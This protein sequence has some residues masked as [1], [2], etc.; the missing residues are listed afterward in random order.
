MRMNGKAF[1]IA[2]TNLR[3][4]LRART[5]IF[6]IFVFPMLLILILGLAFGGSDSPRVGVVAPSQ[7]DLAG[8][9]VGDLRASSGIEV[10]RIGTEAELTSKVEHSELAG[11]LVVPDDYD[12]QVRAGRTVTLRYLAQAGQGGQQ[13]GAVVSAAVDRQSGRILAARAVAGQLAIGFDDSLAR[14]DRA[15]STVDLVTVVTSTTGTTQVPQNA[16]RFDTGASSQLLL[17]LFITSL[18]SSIALIES[19]RLGVSTRMAATPTPAHTII[20]GEGLGR[21]AVA[22]IQALFIM[23]GSALIFGVSWGNPLAAAA[24]TVAFALVASAAGL[25]LGASARTPEQAI[26]VGLLLGMGMGALGGTM[27]PLEFFSPT[28]RRIA[29]ITPHAWGMD[30]FSALL[31]HGGSLLTI[32]P[33]LGVLLG[34]AALLTAL[35]SWRLRRSVSG[36]YM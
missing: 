21:F 28:M 36:S 24:L 25:L 20:I 33:Q 7:G 35:A 29:H 6:F 8:Q 9:L 13:L 27:M 11:G 30:G 12:A 4:T 10:Q 22:A 34:A 14:T 16:G 2:A 15:W 1:T 5:N 26:A 31:H 17:F 19:R 23:L 32:A 3:R 18:T